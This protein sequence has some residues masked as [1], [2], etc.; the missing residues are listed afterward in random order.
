MP[1]ADMVLVAYQLGLGTVCSR[2]HVCSQTKSL[3]RLCNAG[4][5]SY[6]SNSANPL[7]ISKLMKPRR[8]IH[9]DARDERHR[10][11]QLLGEAGPGVPSRLVAEPV[12]QVV[13]IRVGQVSRQ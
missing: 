12:V 7:S 5:V 4:Q 11:E 1:C 2:R 3:G 10:P 6:R 8:L 13:V 9:T